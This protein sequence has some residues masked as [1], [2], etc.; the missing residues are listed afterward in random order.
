MHV[1]VRRLALAARLISPLSHRP[2]FGQPQRVCTR[3]AGALTL[4]SGVSTGQSCGPYR[5]RR[6]TRKVFA[7]DGRPTPASVWD[8]LG[9]PPGLA[10]RPNT[11]SSLSVPAGPRQLNRPAQPPNTTT[12]SL[13]DLILMGVLSVTRGIL[14]HLGA[15]GVRSAEEWQGGPGQG[16]PEA[17]PPCRGGVPGHLRAQ[18]VLFLGQPFSV[19]FPMVE[20]GSAPLRLYVDADGAVRFPPAL[21]SDSVV[22]ESELGNLLLQCFEGNGAVPV[23]VPLLVL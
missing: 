5:Y 7:L 10:A 3:L 4:V 9:A 23:S 20:R 21:V 8:F 14:V 2:W 12:S 16:R 13:N 17:Q 19:E 1:Q 15:V 11:S 22:T 6:I 18:L